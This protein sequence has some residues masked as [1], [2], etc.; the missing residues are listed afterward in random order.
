MHYVSRDVNLSQTLWVM[1]KKYN[2]NSLAA[3]FV[4]SK[5]QAESM[6]DE[7]AKSV[8]REAGIQIG[9]SCLVEK[10]MSK[11]KNEM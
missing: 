8:L 1:C 7:K 3:D 9:Y 10:I 5:V 6:D 2:G 4:L 11:M